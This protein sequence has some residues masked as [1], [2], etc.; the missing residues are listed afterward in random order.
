MSRFGRNNHSGKHSD[1]ANRWY[2][3]GW[4]KKRRLVQLRAHPLCKL[5]LD[6][7][8]ITPANVVDHV[9]PHDG[10]WRKFRWGKLQSLCGPCHDS[11]KRTQEA[12]GYS[13][14][15]GPDGWPVD[16]K[17]PCYQGKAKA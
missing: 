16:P 7:S 13:T 11:V 15:I 2:G 4:W 10:L 3:L 6:R 1:E 5:C 8:I 9:E 12:R 14:A 17:H